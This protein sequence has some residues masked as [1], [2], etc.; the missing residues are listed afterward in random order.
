MLNE[1]TS[2]IEQDINA[3]TGL[4]VFTGSNIDEMLAACNTN[5]LPAAFIFTGIA[6][7]QYT[8]YS[9][10]TPEGT[11]TER[12]F[13]LEHAPLGITPLVI[14]MAL[15]AEEADETAGRLRYAYPQGSIIQVPLEDGDFLA[16]PF[17]L[18]QFRDMPK[19]SGPVFMVT[20]KPENLP[21]SVPL[22]YSESDLHISFSDR[23]A[24]KE[25][26]A[27]YHFYRTKS[28]K[29]LIDGQLEAYDGLFKK[30]R[31]FLDRIMSGNDTFNED[32]QNGRV[33]KEEFNQAYR[34]IAS[35]VPDLYE[36]ALR[37]EPSSSI[38]GLVENTR[39]EMERR[40]DLIADSIGIE[41]DPADGGV[42]EPRGYEAADIYLNTIVTNPD[43]TIQDLLQAYQAQASE[44]SAQFDEILS[45]ATDFITGAMDKAGIK[46]GSLS[47]LTDVLKGGFRR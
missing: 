47:D 25:L 4:K 13:E 20:I 45:G 42:Y 34:T 46:G 24:F 19:Q 22:A 33:S 39:N 44:D 41:R 40:A 11:E 2:A 7:A 15:S 23:E 32:F 26:I 37:Q 8:I 43:A 9:V 17:E 16:L 28:F 10:I 36:R 12:S 29:M 38:R 1:V 35:L 3:K 21:I 31:G 30:K 14:V 27:L 6:P 18:S 5:D